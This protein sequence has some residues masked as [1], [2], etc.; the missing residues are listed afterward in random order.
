MN[1]SLL[2]QRIKTILKELE[3]ARISQRLYV[4]QFKMKAC[5]YHQRDI[6]LE[7][8]KDWQDYNRGD[9]WGGEDVHFCFK[10]ML[11]IP[12]D[13]DGQYV[14][15]SIKTGAE[16]IWNYDNP[17]FLAYIN[18]EL[19][20][21]LDVNH[22][23]FDLAKKAVK[24]ERFELALYAYCSTKLKDVFL[25][26]C[27]AVKE[28]VAEDLYYDLKI[29]FEAAEL[30]RDEETDKLK[31]ISCLNETINL[32]DLRKVG[33]EAFYRS[34]KIADEYLQKT[35]YD[36]YCGS[37]DVVQHCIGHT[38]IDVAWLWSLDQTR[39]K[40]IRSFASVLYL[41]EKYPEYKFMSSQPQLYEFVK[42]D[43]PALY[44]KIKQKIKE[45][46]WETEGAM[47]LEADCNLTSGESLVRQILYGKRF[48]K[49]EFG[50]D[51]K[52][53]WLPDVFG[54][55]A[56]MPQI[57][58]KSGIEYFMTTKIAWNDTNKIPNDTLVWQ[59]IDGTEILTHFITTTNFDKYPELN[60]KPSHSTTYN[61]LLNASQVKGGW[62]RYQNKDIN[63]EILQCYGYGDGGG[64][65]TAEMLE[66]GRRLE[67][68]L[69]GMP[70]VKQTFVTDYFEQLDQRLKNNKYMPRWCGELYLEFH[71]G[72]YTSMARNKK[73]NRL[74][75]FK[76]TDAELFASMNLLSQINTQY[77][78]EALDRCW[79]LTMLNQFH[80]I[81][82]GS[83]IQ[84][85]YEE[86]K[87]QYEE[88]LTLSNN[89]IENALNHIVTRVDVQG[90][91]VVVFNSLGFTRTDIAELEIEEG[92]AAILD[93]EEILPSQVTAEGKVIFIA[94]DIP[95]KGY[96][97]FKIVPNNAV[98][99]PTKAV[100][101][102]KKIETPFYDITLNDQG[103][104]ISIID[105][106]A[107]RELLKE[108]ERGNVLQVF[109]DRP[110][111]YE[112]WN[113]DAYYQEKMWEINDLA[114]IKIQE[115]GP[116][117]IVLSLKRHFMNSV[118]TQK[119]IFYHHSKRIDF[120]TTV[121]WKEEHL[122]LKTAF[123]VDIMSQKAVYEIQYGNVERS[124]HANTSWDMARF[125]VCAHKWADLAENGY[126]IALMN[127]CKYGYD[128]KDSVM[129]LSLIK[130]AT[131]PNP[132]ADKEIHQFTYVLYPHQGDFREG[133]VV[134]SAYALNCPL[135]T[136]GVF[137]Q[138]GSLPMAQSYLSV[139]QENVVI[140]V[141]KR[142]EEGQGMIV[143]VYEAYGRRTKA[144]LEVPHHQTLAV[145]ECDLMEQIQAQI[146]IVGGKAAF[147]I[148]PYEIKT[149]M[150]E[151]SP[152]ND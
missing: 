123:P 103:E 54:Y 27:I 77:P 56:A 83:S 57:L 52:V 62:Q 109:E 127:D 43:C 33:S 23:E 64:G 15:C 39:E 145:Y 66:N 134:Q 40:V 48:F 104:F 70:V 30:L 59:G 5:S 25:E 6:V 95:A 28:Q 151:M 68:A 71:R 42:K 44:D 97:T 139:D 4:E 75:E 86:S 37:Y 65:P 53:L 110:S 20:C 131:Y 105:R 3:G 21:G 10:T 19:I 50:K 60:P 55:S 72:T 84:K 137:G 18:G 69:P 113:I 87:V 11:A 140:E 133:K 143:R 81:L 67:K 2:A 94:K 35:F 45:G 89:L 61:G 85:V 116:V 58:K 96:K 136:K 14:I 8:M 138:G 24:G 141:V 93:G 106:E 126:G 88:A 78:K 82:P 121:D 49:E 16:D 115:N 111:E 144:Q 12:E 152:L 125:E 22:I 117:R 148:K 100:A 46:R 129:R 146:S 34:V 147:E 142:A 118:I 73:Y 128:I 13:F 74:C 47:W 122:L 119:I 91:S 31:T 51:N 107:G 120:D 26:A 114:E 135:Y 29:P 92:G 38:H 108:G 17:Q 130:S 112:A 79:Q 7:D 102:I 90:K 98:P 63:K 36:A 132:E 149:F 32:L 80:D 41:M 1:T 150:L 9:A 124:T 99:A 101:D 76:N